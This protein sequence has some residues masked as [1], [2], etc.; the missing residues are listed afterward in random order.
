M[1]DR[2]SVTSPGRQLFGRQHERDVIDR[3]LND[4]RGGVLVMHGEAGVGKTALLDYAIEAAR[5]FRVVRASGVEAEMELPYAA[6]HLV[7]SPFLDLVDRLPPPQREALGVAFGLSAG[8]PPDPFLVGLAVLG[9]LSEAAVQQPLL[10]AVDDAHWLDHA[11]ARALS[12]VARRLSSEPIALVFATRQIESPL[13]GLPDLLVAPLGH[14]DARAML[15]AVLVAPFDETVLERIV[16][17]TRGNPLA[18][19]ELPRGL[20]A[21]ELAG[22]FGLPPSVPLSAGIEKSFTK[23]LSALPED[24]RRLLLVAAADPVGEP[25]LVW[26]AA[27]RLGIPESAG[28]TVESEELLELGP[29]VVV[30]HPL[31]RSAVYGA[32]TSSERRAVHHALAEATDA[33]L[34]P[35]RRA[36]HRA[37]AA[38]K[39]DEEVAAELEESAARAQARGG[40]AAAAAFL[41]R[42]SALTPDESTRSERALAAAQA[43]LQAGALEDSLRLLATAKAAR[44]TEAQLA[45]AAL[46]RGQ[47]SFASTH[48]GDAA[49]L[50]L[51][52]AE[53]YR[54]MNP[55]LARETYLEALTAAVFAGSLAAPG[56][57]PR[58]VAAAASA[59]PPARVPRAPD[60][61][62]D[63][64][65]AL[66][67]GT[68][69]PAVPVLRQAQIAIEST[70]QTE[71]LRWM[72]AATV[73]AQHLWDDKNWERLSDLHLEMIRDTGRLADLAVALGHRGQM[74]VFAGE[75]TLAASRLEAIQE[76]TE[77]TGSPLAP[78]HGVSLAA[79]RGR[80]AEA[81]EIFESAR[82]DVSGRGEGAGLAFAD[83]AE[84]ILYN[85]LGRYADALAAAR[86]VIGH[87][88]LVCSNWAMPEL[89]EAGARVGAFELAAE[90]DQL[91]AERASASGTEWALGIAARSHALLA[92]DARA[93]DLHVEAIDRLGRTSIAVDLARA[94]LLY[95]EWL[96]RHRQL[97]DARNELRSAYEMFAVFGMEAFATR[98]RVELEAAGERVQ[99]GTVGTLDQLT[100]Q[101]LQVARSAAEGKTNKEI[102]AL[103]FISPSTVEYHMHKAFLKLD[104]KSRRQLAQRKL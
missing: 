82:A 69:G 47:I 73:A 97:R 77:L 84:S 62:L 48:S 103:L 95:G 16:V 1:S 2:S 12:F 14:R 43:K 64:F 92:D 75:L 4:A 7:C 50:L 30:R 10:V 25:S 28:D 31:V 55:E 11:S 32:A 98:T 22:G 101:E 90:T 79:M 15:E 74:H 85:G 40:L 42:A 76:A 19:L 89:I 41:D 45:R 72:W 99:A 44:L 26:R 23:R 53:R 83:W 102:A 38:P 96:R 20:S 51:D 91:L 34:D 87:T 37:K 6:G 9:L 104:I 71:Q 57:R 78:Y 24:A 68:Y 17:E 46:L 5:V 3:L 27:E 80:E 66:F 33:E 58:Q 21:T 29:R 93:A 13:R 94:H 39:P 86:R 52:A 67:S 49:T 88:D 70:S 81:R 35:D 63:G 56:A 65:A 59:A 100:P 8:P 36:W 60:L 18:L 54:E 61:L